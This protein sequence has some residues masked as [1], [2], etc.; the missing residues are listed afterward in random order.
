MVSKKKS[1]LCFLLIVICIGVSIIYFSTTRNNY[2]NK[3]CCI[4]NILDDNPSLA[5]H[6]LE[7]LNSNNLS[8]KEL[9][10]YCL[11][12]SK[13]RSM[14]DSILQSDS[15]INIAIKYYEGNKDSLR[16]SQSYLYK[17]R[18]FGVKKHLLIA[19][20]CFQKSKEFANDSDY[21]TKYLL[22]YSMGKIYHYKMMYSDEKGVK[23]DAIRYARLLNDSI[24]IARAY[25]ELATYYHAVDSFER[26]AHILQKAI[27]ILPY[28]ENKILAN[29]NAELGK[30]LIL[31]KQA[32][33]AIRYLNEAIRLERNNS[34]LYKLYN[35]K[36]DA[37]FQLNQKDSARCFYRLSLNSNEIRTKMTTYY[38][39]A[40]LEK[41]LNKNIEAFR[42]FEKYVE[43][44][45]S[46]D[47]NRKEERL[48]RM[49]SI[50]AYKIQRESIK[51]AESELSK[52]KITIY[53]I[54]FITF[55]VIISLI[56]LYYKV[57]RRKKQL[58]FDIKLE[59]EKTMQAIIK[60][61]ETE[62]RLLEEQEE[63]KRVEVLKLNQT[64]DYYKSLNAMTIP[65]L[66]KSQ[67]N[68]GAMKL[69][70]VEWDVIIRNTDACFN[71]FTQRLQNYCTLL[72]KEDIQFCCL[73]KMELS[74]DLL[75]EIYH[76]EKGSISR[77]KIRLKE[78]LKIENFSFDE[79]IRNF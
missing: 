69:T 44:R 38:G 5:I 60:Q 40:Q 11:L 34:N 33:E 46:L 74:I 9:A 17:G 29:A 1:I 26:S 27:Q 76:I 50:Q 36:A 56:V 14:N 22:D 3:L 12:L 77:K 13:G 48:D 59:E 28:N 70:Q 55:I 35:L 43:Y 18:I 15:L 8:S 31:N 51:A 23:K 75:S 79:F 61:K 62:Y 71:L 63:R 21:E 58:E 67:N 20:E 64:V 24:K 2:I 52:K 66:L 37:Y 39:L 47:L 78:K 57:Q 41:E 65:I 4:E 32:S 30:N 54:I 7:Q 45:D 73:V 6:E 53:R 49:E 19:S 42:Y 16:L 72:T 10:L 68:Q 25:I